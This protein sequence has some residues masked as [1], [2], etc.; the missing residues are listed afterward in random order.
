MGL[1]SMQIGEALSA[2]PLPLIVGGVPFA[3]GVGLFFV[4]RNLLREDRQADG[5]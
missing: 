4:G 5:K 1:N 2:L 3:I